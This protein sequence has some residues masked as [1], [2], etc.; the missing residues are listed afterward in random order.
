MSVD[1]ESIL[2]SLPDR[3]R[4]EGNDVGLREGLLYLLNQRHDLSRVGVHDLVSATIVG[5]CNVRREREEID[6]E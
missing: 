6:D 5:G 1:S 4:S 2:A 3:D